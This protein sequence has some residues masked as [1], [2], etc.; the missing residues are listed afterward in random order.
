MSDERKCPHCGQEIIVRVSVVAPEQVRAAGNTPKK[1]RGKPQSAAAKKREEKRAAQ[2]EASEAA[3]Q[4]SPGV[5]AGSIF[6]RDP[7]MAGCLRCA[8]KH[9]PPF[10]C[11]C[12][13]HQPAAAAPPPPPDDGGFGL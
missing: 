6:K 2:A 1:T 11:G 10:D 5:Q 7:L 4:V 8:V 12:P 13:C 3:K 9:P